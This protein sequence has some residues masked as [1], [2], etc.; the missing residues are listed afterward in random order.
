VVINFELP[1]N[2]VRLDQRTGRVDRIGQRRRV[3]TFHLVA[4]EAGERAVADRLEARRVQADEDLRGVSTERVD[5]TREIARLRALRRNAPTRGT[6]DLRSRDSNRGR[7]VETAPVSVCIGG[8]PAWRAALG[9]AAIVL[10][11]LQ[12]V[13]PFGREVAARLL[14]LRLALT[15]GVRIRSSAEIR[16]LIGSLESFEP[17]AY[18]RAIDEWIETNISVS[19]A[20]WNSYRAREHAILEHLG[21]S[22]QAYRQQS[23]F[24]HRVD[25]AD[26]MD[27]QAR[28]IASAE[29][30]LM[31]AEHRRRLTVS[32]A[33]VLILLP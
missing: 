4:Y 30:R 9:S 18:D 33:P 22:R 32:T 6:P 20:F 12:L 16:R 1:W 13:D 7:V 3:H 19:D 25:A 5:V 14:P 31:M 26:D 17:A 24:T 28:S 10:M 15:P 21:V 2:P 23:L 8:R 27:R 11:Q 29:F